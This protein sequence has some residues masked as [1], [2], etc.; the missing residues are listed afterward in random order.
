M[1]TPKRRR[2]VRIMVTK[3]MFQEFNQFWS[4][5]DKGTILDG[6]LDESGNFATRWVHPITKKKF[7]LTIYPSHYKLLGNFYFRKAR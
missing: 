4:G 3:T 7:D 1:E 6:R 2:D 5:P